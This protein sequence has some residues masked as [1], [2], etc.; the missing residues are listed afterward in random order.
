M[1]K[2]FCT[3]AVI[4]ALTSCMSSYNLDGT[5]NVSLLDGRML[6]LKVFD[7]D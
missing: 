4:A 5:T 6:Y 2:L 3:L 1:N 7:T